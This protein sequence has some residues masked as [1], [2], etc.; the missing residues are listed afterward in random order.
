VLV[1]FS[2]DYVFDG[3][4]ERPYRETD[5][6]SPLNAYGRSKL[7]GEDAVRAALD[8]HLIVRSSWL[9]APRGRNFLR[10][11]LNLG[12]ARDRV[13]VVDDQYGNPTSARALAAATVALL[14]RVGFDARD[15]LMR[16]AG[17]YHLAATGR[18][19][20][21]AFAKRIYALSSLGADA[22]EVEAISSAR[23]AARATRPACSALDCGK[24]RALGVV[25]PHWSESLATTMAEIAAQARSH[26]GAHGGSN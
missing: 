17:T 23:F 22:P 7:D 3:K 9:Y 18:C 13:S 26:E 10:T 6:A 14:K 15:R 2:T 1:H 19:S 5:P 12:R 21:C 8:A 25:L 16:H 20:W 11:M 24:A 4:G